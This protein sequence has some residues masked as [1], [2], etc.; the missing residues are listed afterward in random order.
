MV[1][2]R[3][4][5]WAEKSSWIPGVLRIWSW[6]D[7]SGLDAVRTLGWWELRS[8]ICFTVWAHRRGGAGWRML[9]FFT[10]G[11]VTPGASLLLHNPREDDEKAEMLP[12]ELGDVQNSWTT[13]ECRGKVSTDFTGFLSYSS[14]S[15]ACLL[16]LGVQWA[17]TTILCDFLFR[18][19]T[20]ASHKPAIKQGRQNSKYLIKRGTLRPVLFFCHS[21]SSGSMESPMAATLQD[22]VNLLVFVLIFLDP[23]PPFSDWNLSFTLIPDYPW[24][25][26]S[27]PWCPFSFWGGSSV[28][29][30]SSHKT[31][32]HSPQHAQ[33]WPWCMEESVSSVNIWS[34]G[35][36]GL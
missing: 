19:K 32:S 14:H 16:S 6:I 25:H 11:I 33:F 20:H 1:Y 21:A 4:G 34:D 3:F 12:L 17:W 8:S 29:F 18:V 36:S 2:D 27:C 22:P 9:A 31:S 35:R 24:C 5:A 7:V 26:A 13:T 28:E 15:G 30:P 23:Y 10:E